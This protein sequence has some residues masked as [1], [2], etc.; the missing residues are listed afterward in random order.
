MSRIRKSVEL[1]ERQ[2][3]ELD[4]IAQRLGLRSWRTVVGQLGD[5]ALAISAGDVTSEATQ[6]RKPVATRSAAAID[7]LSLSRAG[8][9]P[10][11]GGILRTGK[12]SDPSQ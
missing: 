11:L 7:D 1:S 8:A 12:R 9:K 6:P 10:L 3:I 5:G 2:W 4:G